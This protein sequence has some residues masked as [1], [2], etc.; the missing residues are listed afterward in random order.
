MIRVFRGPAALSDFRRLPLLQTCRAIEPQLTGIEANFFY[1]VQLRQPL[2]SDQLERLQALLG[3]DSGPLPE[4][5]EELAVGPRPGTI[6]PWSSKATDILHHCGLEQVERVERGTTF[7]LHGANAAMRDRLAPLLFDRMTEAVIADPQLFFDR[8]EPQPLVHIPLGDSG[9]SALETANQSMGLALA[10]DEIDYL[11]Q[12]YADLG[13]DPTDVELMMFAVVNSEHCRHKIFNASWNIDGTD[14]DHTLFAM[15]RH[16]HARHPK[17]CV[18]AYADNSAIV[19]GFAVDV[20]RPGSPGDPYRFSRK[21]THLLLKVETHN[22]P[23][24]IA[25][26]PGASTG[27]GGEIRDEG[28]AGTGGQPQA[29][30]NAFFTSHLRLPQHPQPWELD[31]AEFPTRLATPLAIMTEG[32]IGGAAFGNEF[33]RPNILGVFRTFEEQAGGRYRGYHKPI[34]VAGGVGLIDAEHV[35]KKQPQ[36]GDHVIQLG[37]PAMLIGLGGGAASSMDTGS[38]LEDLDFASVQRDNP[39]M[40]RRCQEL[41][42]RCIALGTDN[43]I[44]SIHDIGAGGLSNACP[45]LVED[46]GA[47]FDLRA[48]HNDDPGMSPMQIWS[49]EAQ[50]RYVLVISRDDLEHFGALAA[51]ERCLWAAIGEITGDGKLTLHDPLFGNY[52][53]ADL[54]LEVILGKPPRMERRVHHRPA[55]MVPLKTQGIALSETV[56]RVLRFPAVASKTFLITIADR[57]VTGLIA[58]DQMVGPYQVPISDMALTAHS[59]TGYTGS[60]MAMGERTPLALIDAAASVRMA[61]AESITN[62]AAAQ[63]GPIGQ[64]KLSANWMCA[65]GEEGEDAALYRAVEAVGMEFCPALGIAIPVGKDSLS[66]R[67]VWED[68]QGRAQQNVAPL[69]LVV[70]AFAPVPDVRR[71]AT[72][73]LKPG[74]DTRL[75]L[76]DLGRG[77]NRLGG[78]VLAQ[79][80]NQIGDNCPDIEP[81]D[82]AALYAAV[83]S[84]LSENLLLAYHDRSDGGLFACLAEMAFGGRRGLSVDIA[85][86]GPDQLG[87]LF[88]EEIGVVLQ[89][90]AADQNAVDAILTAHQLEDV[91]HQLGVVNDSGIIALAQNGQPLFNAPVLDL[92]QTWSEVTYHM[93]A[94]RDNPACSRQEYEAIADA[95]DPG[96]TFAAPGP[97]PTLTRPQ[98][99]PRVA[100]LREQGING[101]VEMAAAFDAGGCESVDVTMTDLLE[102]RVALDQFQGLVACGGFSFGDVLGAGVGWARSIL[103]NSQLRDQ[104]AAFFARP[105][106]FGLGVCNGCQM[107]SHLKELIPGAHD[108]PSFQRNHSEQFEARFATVEVL[109]SP[110]VLLRGLE[111][112]RLGIAVAHGEGRTQFSAGTQDKAPTS[113]RYVDNHGQPTESYPYNPN[114]S[115]AGLTGFTSQDGRVTIMMPHPERVFRTLQLSWKPPEWDG[116]YTPWLQLFQN[117]H[118]FASES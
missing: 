77:H 10:P 8:V 97:L 104:F 15:I 27:V 25:P 60:A 4:P 109:P 22:H 12:V 17:G 61:V 35:D 31:H 30:L 28:A 33:G 37:G 3:V 42:N 81:Q 44:L 13:R 32:P 98:Q 102:G 82:L 9:R 38:N 116:D 96:L 19:E 92:H 41:L 91:A 39:E 93:Q 112:A 7:R 84:L 105:E 108:W 68:S 53:I 66:M 50:E 51:R 106:T 55:G 87:A 52:P 63:L 54:D 100:V 78:S 6:S 94:Q 80:Y 103:F 48:V 57:T 111:G 59:F 71:L 49:N 74:T 43:P 95:A 69:S 62:I 113:L 75:L 107:L 2:N 11:L 72:P 70:T 56:G 114:G 64:I 65:C 29:G 90:R 118:D 36:P 1:A 46:S 85:A 76:I 88:N 21:Q 45:E 115:P 26:Y 40:E 79:V 23:T 110:S 34:M 83:Q 86:L 47:R 99:R 18:V 20:F 5:S 89:Y 101:Q 117:A 14:R 24:A 67:T 16:T 58:R 73:D